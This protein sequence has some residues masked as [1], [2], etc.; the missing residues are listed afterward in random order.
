MKKPLTSFLT[1]I[2]VIILILVLN[3][4]VT[5]RQGINYQWHTIK[6][7][8][9]LKILDFFDRHYNYK[10]L[11]K[12]ITRDAKTDQDRVMKLFEWTHNNIRKTPEGFPVIDDHVWSIIIRGYGASDQ[13]C[14][15]LATLCNYADIKSFYLLVRAPE[16]K[17]T[18]PLTFVKLS[19]NWY[20]FDPYRGAYFKNPEDGLADIDF[21]KSNN[22]WIVETK[23]GE[24]NID[25]AVYFRNLPVIKKTILNRSNIQSPFKRLIFELKKWIK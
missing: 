3:I 12:V 17:K 23:G 19:M 11:V 18:I 10:Q 21:L 4:N 13:S 25:Y 7:P 8:F 2:I 1:I 16:Q 24:S 14:D 20:V 22:S 6:L 5:T 9:Y 15:V